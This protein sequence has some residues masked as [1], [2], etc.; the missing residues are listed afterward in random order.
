MKP[1]TGQY[2]CVHRSGVGLDHF[3]SRL[4]RLTLYQNGRFLLIIQDRSRIANAAQ[5]LLKGQ[6]ISTAA[7]QTRREGNY[8]VQGNLLLLNFDDG[9]QLRG[10][11]AWNGEGVQLEQNFF[12]KV[13]DST[14]LP[15]TQRLQKDMEDI[16]KG[17]KI[18]GT[19]GK[20]AI[21]AAK[22]I[23]ETVQSAQAPQQSSP[24]QPAQSAPAAY[25]PAQSTPEPVVPQATSQSHGQQSSTET[26][27]C[28]QCGA[29]V[30]PGK[31]FCNQ[32]GA[33][34]P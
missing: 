22:T 10:Q 20:I 27:Y 32:C 8:S 7:P 23:H 14:F 29:R 15:P 24:P 1:I 9:V 34:L 18:A 28:D 25:N 13:S 4:D 33:W 19:I 12:N 5:S 16:A 2:E 31:H 3:T 30:R 17:L 21:K 11:V 26:L 6:Q